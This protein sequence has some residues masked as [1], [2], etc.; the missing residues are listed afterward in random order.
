MVLSEEIY[1]MQFCLLDSVTIDSQS[2]PVFRMFFVAGLL[3][4]KI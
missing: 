2:T 4:M 3:D 1:M